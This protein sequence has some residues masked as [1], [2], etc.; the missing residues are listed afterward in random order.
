MGSRIL[1]FAASLIV[2]GGGWPMNM[3]M[4]MD[5][6]MDMN[7]AKPHAREVCCIVGWPFGFLED[8]STEAG[9]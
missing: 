3:N 2:R 7:V 5:M 1:Q 8:S 6:D 9:N 4:D